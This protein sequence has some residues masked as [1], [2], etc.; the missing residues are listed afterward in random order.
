MSLF[1]TSPTSK[2]PGA[3]LR[4]RVPAEL[5]ELLNETV[6]VFGGGVSGR[7]AEALLGRMGVVC[8]V[9]DETGGSDFAVPERPFL[10]VVSP[11]FR[12][13]HP[14]LEQA[15]TAGAEII[16]ELDLGFFAWPGPVWAVTG[17]NGKS[18]AVQ[19]L[20][21]AL[22]RT[23]QKAVACG[24]N[25]HPLAMA[26]VQTPEAGR[27][28]VVE[29]SSFQAEHSRYFHPQALL[30]LNFQEDHLDRHGTMARYFAAK[31]RL[32]EALAG[33]GLVIGESV[34]RTARELGFD[35]P[36][37]TVVASEG[38]N[39]E[40][41]LPEK[42]AFYRQPQRGNLAVI[43]PFWE[44]LQR[45]WEDLEKA[46]Q[47]LPSLP[48]RLSFAGEIGGRRFWNDSKATNV[49]GAVAA[50]QSFAQPPL[51]LG[52]GR[53]KGG[54]LTR[55]AERIAPLVREAFLFGE[56]G[57]LVQPVW[58]SA[59]SAQAF[60]GLEEAFHT[61]W[62]RSRPGDDILLS[63]G[64]ASHDAFAGYAARGEAFLGLISRLRDSAA[65]LTLNHG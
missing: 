6:V 40:L 35:L 8:R 37:S 26:A 15:R 51:W 1:E 11:G 14:W 65:E 61:A 41:A 27:V 31:W 43:R 56:A 28:A 52:G 62:E 21:S 49:D 18:T 4:E 59:S 44:T 5:R 60:D 58:P 22:S 57:R 10:A 17:T 3:S 34:A 32:V 25:G 23:G 2:R 36:E 16:S 33:P 64:F 39:E 42:S 13:D 30:W 20:A 24:N 19:V 50:L 7:A 54:D 63:P 53:V 12:P 55:Y 45:P 38:G 47:A 46:A 9:Y 29:V 48:H